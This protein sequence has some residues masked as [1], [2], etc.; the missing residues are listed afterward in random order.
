MIF[1]GK[2]SI[3]WI[4]D[5]WSRFACHHVSEFLSSSIDTQ[6]LVLHN[7]VPGYVSL[8]L[9]IGLLKSDLSSGHY[10]SICINDPEGLFKSISSR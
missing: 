2:I 6:L 3:L 9:F 10:S 1:I 4:I 5:I 8:A 7:V